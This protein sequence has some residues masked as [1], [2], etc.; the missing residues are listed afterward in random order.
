MID[1]IKIPEK[2]KK[3]LIRDEKDR[4]NIEKLTNTIITIEEDIKIEGEGLQ[5]YQT[6]QVL[7][8]FGRGF[9]VKDALCLLDDDYGLEII[10]LPDFV[11]SKN[12]MTVIK[13]RIIGTKG[14]T[15]KMVEKYT[16]TKIS[17]QG[18]TVSILGKWDKIDVSKEAI[19]MIIDGS[20]HATLYK[21]LE[22]Q[23]SGVKKW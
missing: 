6:K 13:G 10:N 16:E 17:I 9:A 22:Q 1:F 19:M 7:K 12:R 18:K 20:S 21:W 14:K 5:V 15:K 4:R 11:K 8:A 2:M 3:V 23:Y